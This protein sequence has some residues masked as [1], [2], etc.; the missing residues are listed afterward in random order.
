MQIQNPKHG[1]KL[2]KFLFQKFEEIPYEW[3][4][5]KLIE[6]CDEKPQYG[7]AVSALPEA[8]PLPRYIR[9]TDIRDDG[10]LNDDVVSI[11]EED[12][13]PFLLSKGDF[14]FARTGAT[15]GKTYIYRDKDGHSAFAG[16]LIR[17]K[18]NEQK[19]NAEFLFHYCHS[20]NY[21]RWLRSFFTHWVQ[22]NVN[23]EQYSNLLIITPTF[24]EQHKI[25]SILSKVDDFIQKTDKIIEQTQ[26]LKKGLMKRL[27]TKGIGH[28]KFKVHE[29]GMLALEVPE[30]WSV[31]AFNEIVAS[32]KNGI[33]KLPEYYGKGFVSIRMF[34]IVNG[35]IDPTGAPLLDV[36]QEELSDYALKIGDI[37]V[38]RVNTAE[39][40][41]KAGLV[42]RDL[43]AITF[44]SKNIRIR[45]KD[46]CSPEFL[47]Y[48]M[49][50]ILYYR[51]I[52]TNIKR[53][54]GQSTL[55][56]SDLN[57]IFVP[58]PP[59]EEQKEIVSI[60]NKV[61][62]AIELAMR[63]RTETI[64]LKKGLMQQLLTGKFRVK[65]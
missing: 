14:L 44:E 52:R 13:R 26:R 4:I 1:Y 54:I 18:P 17:F 56:Q 50:S 33:Y 60:L 20:A 36:S 23:A 61:D 15:V 28:T 59:I 8:K 64:G 62:A 51:Q 47:A 5:V 32:Y 31:R 42:D 22:P 49:N 30:N 19:L 46:N 65:V 40:V 9:I 55:N 58:L 7:A 53:A 63:Y 35:K 2:S 21:W 24:K 6:L 12:A 29:F 39:L 16:Y 48:F 41:G 11:S 43:G 3:G 27:L 57:N 10:T 38:N 37:L 25:A 45:V 34:N